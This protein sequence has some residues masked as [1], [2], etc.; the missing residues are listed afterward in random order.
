MG[1]EKQDHVYASMASL[2][3]KPRSRRTFVVRQ[4]EPWVGQ[5]Q[6]H[7]DPIAGRTDSGRKFAALPA[8][9]VVMTID[10]DLMY[11]PNY[12]RFML[13]KLDEYPGAVVTLLGRKVLRPPEHYYRD[14]GWCE[15]YDWR[16]VGSEDR[17]V[18]IPGTGVSMFR[19]E[20]VPI[21][22]PDDF[23]VENAD[24]VC[25]GV[26][27][28]K[29]EIPVYKVTPPFSVLSYL[30]NPEPTIFSTGAAAPECRVRELI[31]ET[32]FAAEV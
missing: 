22:F 1:H 25:F 2:P 9:G 12:I 19:A 4:L 6:V 14:V 3:T 21:R 30:G 13:Q 31:R 24:D 7:L 5:V 8:E 18:D 26:F 28:A 17:R 27:C 16:E 10:D 11:G 23:P 32:W 20:D 29:H 15:R